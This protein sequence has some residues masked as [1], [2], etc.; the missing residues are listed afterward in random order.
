MVVSALT[1]PLS[2]TTKPKATLLNPEKFVG[3][4]FI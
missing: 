4:P 3:T 1:T 2:T